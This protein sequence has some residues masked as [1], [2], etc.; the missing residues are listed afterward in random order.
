MEPSK[1]ETFLTIC[2]PKMS[3]QNMTGLVAEII[4]SFQLATVLLAS[5][6]R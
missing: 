6:A 4:D 2:F 1:F 3:G 5:A